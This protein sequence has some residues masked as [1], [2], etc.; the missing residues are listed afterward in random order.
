MNDTANAGNEIEA[1]AAAWLARQDAGGLMAEEQHQFEGWLQAS[2]SHRVAYLRLR[3]AWDGADR[4]RGQPVTGAPVVVRGRTWTAWKLAAGVLFT[5]ALGI[6]FAWPRHESDVIA[7]RTQVGENR[8]IALSDGSR[9]TLNTATHLHTASTTARHA[10]LDGGEAYFDVAH[11]PAHPFVVEAG[12]DRITVLGTRFSVRR[13]GG[14]THVLVAEGH[15]RVGTAGTT[16]DLWPNQEA[17]VKGTAIVRTQGDAL[18]TDSRLAWREGRLVFDGATLAQA[19]AEFNR[20]NRRQLVIAD[21]QAGAMTIGGSFAP[22]NLDGFV[23]L[24]EQGFALHAR[25][26]GDRIIVSR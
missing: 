22:T 13:E 16:V 26:D 15:V 18:H 6:L 20:Y 17:V 7:Y 4:L 9:I 12:A 23:R 24:L 1:Q 19:A 5:G 14:Q 10:W 21:A 3:A 11:D 8:T 25:R 2:T